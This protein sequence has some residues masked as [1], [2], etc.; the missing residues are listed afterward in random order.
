MK[1][2]RN[3]DKQEGVIK[4]NHCGHSDN[5]SGISLLEVSRDDGNIPVIDLL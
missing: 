5:Y 2:Y 1:E 4:S 3:G